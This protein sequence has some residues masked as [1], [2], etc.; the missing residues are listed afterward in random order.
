MNKPATCPTA[1]GEPCQ[2]MCMDE[3]A[4]DGRKLAQPKP[5]DGQHPY[6]RTLKGCGH[7]VLF[8]DYCRDCEIV[9]LQEQYKNAI[10]TVQSVR[11]RLRV[12]GQ[13]MPGQTSLPK[14]QT[15]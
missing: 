11:D 10:R 13:P 9:Q 6:V 1:M 5:H 4:I 7:G 15:P 14:D 3:C 8:T 12:L 2:C